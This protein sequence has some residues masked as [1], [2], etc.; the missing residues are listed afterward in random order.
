[1]L[2]LCTQG[3]FV[4]N[5]VPN[6]AVQTP[7]MT[8]SEARA[9]QNQGPAPHPTT[10]RHLVVVDD[11]REIRSLLSQFLEKHGFR[12]TAVADGRSL[13]RLVPMQRIDLVV[14]DVML[15]GGEDGRTRGR[16]LSATGQMPIIMRTGKSDEVDRIIGLEI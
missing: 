7:N 10:A 13:R 9:P 14:L 1:M 2:R 16:Q 11:D 12:V 4:A 6:R 15:P 3:N 5:N 8:T